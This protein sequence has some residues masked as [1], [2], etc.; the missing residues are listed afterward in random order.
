MSRVVAYLGPSM[1]VA[2]AQRRSVDLFSA[3]EAAHAAA[4]FDLLFS[5]Q[6]YSIPVALRAA[7]LGIPV[8]LSL[9]DTVYERSGGTVAAASAA[10]VEKWEREG[11]RVSSLVV[12]PRESTRRLVVERHLGNRQ[13]VL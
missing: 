11:V 5:H 3:L 6:W 8:V 1:Q 7:A 2:E 10:A 12:V 9:C 13:G 4:P